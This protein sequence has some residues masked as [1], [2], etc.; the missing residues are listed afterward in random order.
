MAPDS[1][2]GKLHRS[3]GLLHATAMN[4][5]NMVGVGPFLTIPAILG[6]MGGPP[7]LLGWLAG[8]V[9]AI[10]D[11]M[12]WAELAS[13]VPASGGSFEYLRAAFGGTRLARLLPFL[14]IWQFL[15]SGPL[16]AAS[17]N[18]GF[19]Q[20]ATYLLSP[21]AREQFKW[22]LLCAPAVVGALAVLL[23][24]RK[25]ESV[26]RLMVVL[27]VG[28][29]VTLAA[30]LVPG[31][32]HFDAGAALTFPSDA[33][34][35][36]EEAGG[37][38][39]YHEVLGLPANT[40]NFVIGFALGLGAATR[41]AMYCFLGYYSV[42]YIGDEVKA[43]SRTIP[44]SI[45]ISVA[46]VAVLYL[47]MSVSI[48][49]VVPWQDA[50]KSNFIGSEFMEKLYG[51]TAGVLLTILICWTAFA[52][53]FALMLGYSRIPY[54]AARDGYFF[55]AFA[56]L[57]PRGD[58]PHVSLLVLGAVTI[59]ASFFPL[60]NVINA[61]MVTRILVQFIAQIA[62]VTLLRRQG[63]ASGFRMALYPLPSVVALF[64]WLFIFSTAGT[65]YVLGGLATLV[66]GAGAYFVWSKRS[67]ESLESADRPRA[68][69]S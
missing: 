38:P 11:G 21:E 20:Y 49:S 55:S 7:A 29:I 18:I 56:R 44:R 63:K 17:G 41:N 19:V 27:W 61:M 69:I 32:W 65:W 43:P 40:L 59:G 60:D 47:A 33:F 37:R 36:M 13:A 57:H 14:F 6:A 2:P 35:S 67:R 45:L 48:I 4:M 54:A 39:F 52:S 62:A 26:G 24:Y 58:F 3:F 30:V 16:E 50:V 31:L 10:C 53:V 5:S 25:I 34:S 8:T 23:L 9:I 46:V 42:C 64:G 12:V 1:Q 22:L 51:R 15:L 68:F 28:V 66:L